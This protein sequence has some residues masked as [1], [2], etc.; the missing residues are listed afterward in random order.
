MEKQKTYRFSK[1][2]YYQWVKDNFGI[3][4]QDRVTTQ[5]DLLTYLLKDCQTIHPTTIVNNL[6][7]QMICAPEWLEEVKGETN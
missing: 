6:G 2:K 1:E 4:R 3:E 7:R 5:F